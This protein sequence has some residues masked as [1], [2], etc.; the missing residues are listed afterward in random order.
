MVISII[1]VQPNNPW[2]GA[3]DISNI[4]D[5]PWVLPCTWVKWLHRKSCLHVIHCEV[6]FLPQAANASFIHTCQL[7]TC[8]P[9]GTR[10]AGVFLCYRTGTAEV[11]DERRNETRCRLDVEQNAVFFKTCHKTMPQKAAVP[12]I[13]S[14]S[15]TVKMKPVVNSPHTKE[16]VKHT[17]C[18]SCDCSRWVAFI[19]TI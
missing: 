14:T 6:V 1:S 11:S 16:H 7:E 2:V 9:A 5:V 12:Q 15:S 19:V 18:D 13:Y 8:L 3:G 10:R 4:L 17:S